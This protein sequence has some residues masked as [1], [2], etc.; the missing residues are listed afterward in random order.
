MWI[1]FD[2][3][4]MA[5]YYAESQLGDD[6]EYEP[7]L[8]CKYCRKDGFHWEQIAD[9]WRLFTEKGHPHSCKEGKSIK[10]NFGGNHGLRT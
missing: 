2:P 1:N 4:S 10:L 7:D 9:G 5:A 8:R 6:E 3:D